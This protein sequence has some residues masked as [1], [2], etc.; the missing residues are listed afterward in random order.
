MNPIS[1]NQDS[2]YR[3]SFSDPDSDILK[4]R[5][6]HL[7]KADVQLKWRK[8]GFGV[9]S[10][11]NSYMSNIDLVFESSLF[12]QELLPGLKDYRE[13]YNKGVFV[14]DMRL[15]YD[16]TK[17]FS[18]NFILNNLFNAEYVS[19]PGDVQPPRSFLVQLRYGIH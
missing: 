11:Y 13:I 12:G 14:F 8:Y 15:L 18:V 10:R 6:N 16:I 5:F 3:A 1:L 19:R 4:Y 17:D 9:S 7:F 2:A